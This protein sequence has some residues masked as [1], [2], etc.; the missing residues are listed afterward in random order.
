MSNMIVNPD[1]LSR[2]D[3]ARGLKLAKLAP[4]AGGW[5]HL[6]NVQEGTYI[7]DN[8]IR[9]NTANLLENAK[10]WLWACGA[11]KRN[12]KGQWVIDEAQTSVLL[13][14]LVDNLFPMIRAG[15]PN[16]PINDLHAVQATNKRTATFVYLDFVAGKTKGEMIAGTKIFDARNGKR[17][18]NPDYS[19][20]LVKNEPQ[21]NSDGT[22]TIVGTL[23]WHNGL[24]VRPGTVKITAYVSST[25][26]IFTD[27]GNGKWTNSGLE[28]TAGID[29]KTGVYTIEKSSGTFDNDAAVVATYRYNSEGSDIAAEIDAQLSFNMVETTRRQY[30]MRRTA[31]GAFDLMTEL[32]EDLDALQLK[33]TTEN[34]TNEILRELNLDCWNAA[35]STLTFPLTGPAGYAKLV[36]Y[37]DIQATIERAAQNVTTRIQRLTPNWITAD[38]GG[39]ALLRTLPSSMFVQAPLPANPEGI[40]FMGTLMGRFSVFYDSLQQLYPDASTYGNLMMGC[41]GQ[42]PNNVGM[43]FMPYQ[44]FYTSD[45]WESAGFNR[46]QGLASRYAKKMVHPEAYEL[47]KLGS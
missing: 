4:G 3:Y 32:G 43:Q 34:L 2:V 12:D 39:A 21:G 16:S 46:S 24:G 36:H 8:L 37:Q 44:M 29:Y 6:F 13:G 9:S 40:Y 35:S 17:S 38:G 15:F 20:E 30:I 5:S 27:D 41:K 26:V 45:P 19:S 7:E 31:E 23:E 28:A 33:A 18:I 42:Y 11:K 25:P 10:N 47:I 1:G 14:G 22:D